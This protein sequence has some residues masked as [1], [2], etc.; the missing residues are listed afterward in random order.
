MRVITLTVALKSER[1]GQCGFGKDRRSRMRSRRVPMALTS[2]ARTLGTSRVS[3]AAV[4]TVKA[5]M[6]GVSDARR[7]TENAIKR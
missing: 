1:L 5:H 3:R 4:L 7:Q 2:N 6:E